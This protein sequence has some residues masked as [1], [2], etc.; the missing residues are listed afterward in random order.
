M[1]ERFTVSKVKKRAG[2][3]IWNFWL[4]P[5]ERKNDENKG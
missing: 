1:F 5:K 3:V 2:F 4:K